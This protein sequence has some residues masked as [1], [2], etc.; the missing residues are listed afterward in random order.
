MTHNF[1]LITF[2]LRKSDKWVHKVC[3]YEKLLRSHEYTCTNESENTVTRQVLDD[4]MILFH[5][6]QK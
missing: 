1:K 3:I 5:S 6:I 4:F 2:T